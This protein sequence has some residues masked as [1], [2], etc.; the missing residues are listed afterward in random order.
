MHESAITLGRDR[1]ARRSAGR[2]HRRSRRPARTGW[3]RPAGHLL[4]LRRRAALPQGLVFP[5]RSTLLECRV[6]D[7]SCGSSR[8]K[9]RSC[10]WP[11]WACDRATCTRWP[12]RTGSSWAIGSR[13][14]L[15]GRRKDL[16][17]VAVNCGRAAETCFCTSMETGPAV[18]S[19]FDLCLTELPEHFVLEV[20]TERG[21]E[22]D[23]RGPLGAVQHPRGGRGP[24]GAPRGRAADGRAPSP[25]ARAA[26]GAARSTPAACTTCC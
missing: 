7:G 3:P 2:L 17:V 8:R 20:G 4:R 15:R 13:S 9:S 6:E 5:P 24:A 25:A 23:R 14:R 12:S 21:G 1:L 11:S 18:S 26:A 22:V 19:G 10:R 16:F